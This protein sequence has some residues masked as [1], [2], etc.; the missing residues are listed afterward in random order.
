MPIKR[1]Q[2]TQ[3]KKYWRE[4]LMAVGLALFVG[5]GS[6]D[7]HIKKYRGNSENLYYDQDD[8]EDG[9]IIEYHGSHKRIRKA[10]G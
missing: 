4:I 8:F 10:D 5:C 2:E 9:D 1:G 6:D 7:H 3:M